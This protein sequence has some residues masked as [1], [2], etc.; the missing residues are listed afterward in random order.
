MKKCWLIL[1][2]CFIS[3]CF[4]AQTKDEIKQ[5]HKVLN[6]ADTLFKQEEYKIM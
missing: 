6:K 3:L 5:I 1:I 2:I 4:N